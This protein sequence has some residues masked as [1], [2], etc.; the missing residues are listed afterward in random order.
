MVRTKTI[1]IPI[2]FGYFRIIVAD[3]FSDV[4]LGGATHLK[5][6]KYYSAFVFTDYTP[7]DIQRFTIVVKPKTTH[8]IIAHEVVH[9]VNSLF[10]G[11]GI[12]LD[13]HNDEPQAYLTGWFT[14]EIYKFIK[15]ENVS[16]Y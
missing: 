9:L 16:L 8:S 5:D 15:P 14:K 6:V 11:R 12:T 7:K 10:V 1:D 4:H 13:A 3:D 2:Y